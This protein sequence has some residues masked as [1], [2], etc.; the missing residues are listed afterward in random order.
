MN[1]SA[2][3]LLFLAGVGLP[4]LLAPCARAEAQGT[5]APVVQP[6]RR[7]ALDPKFS[8]A[9]VIAG[10][11]DGDGA[12]EIVSARNVNQNDV[13]FTCA[14]VA[15]H[16][17]GRVLWRW[18]NPAIGRKELHHD[19]A[20]QIYD[21]DG[22]GRN[23]VV[24]CTEDSLVE[25]DGA[26]GKE[27]RRLP[28][29]KDASDCLVFVNL[30]GK[31]HATDVLVKDRY[32]QIWAFN[33]D[34]KQLWTVRNPGGYKTAHQPVPVDLDGDD[35]DEIMAGFAMLNPDGSTR[36]TF[37]SQKVDQNRG[38]CDCFRLVRAG[39]KPEDFRFVMTLCGANGIALL[40]GGGKPLW[41]ITGH[42]FESVD[43]GRICANSQGLQFAVDIDH[44]PKGEGPVWIIDENGQVK[45]RIKA[46][47]VRFH[48]LVDW[49]GDGLDEIVMAQ[50]RA[51]YDGQ[52]RIVARLA[53]NP[54]DDTDGA[55]IVMTGDFTG[56]GV[57]DVMLTTKAMTH[58]FIYKNE[59]GRKPH[60]SA[61]LGTG[62]NFTL[63]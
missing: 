19:V 10:D 16:L 25:L 5:A 59:R 9:W 27:K 40:D 58:V 28:L 41:E 17:D 29:P 48:A 47:W 34:W 57:P 6:W 36:W 51:L 8:G 3:N 39:K 23:E 52:G 24:L 1:R 61:P 13:H 55:G 12:V 7:I 42:H 2:A 4:W 43:V 33:H 38:H 62:V 60:P 50:P 14:V 37:Q 21:W 32:N 30:S 35:R 15:Q 31:P 53:M 22:D 46:D 56:D 26:T 20:C 18:G 11:L 63:Y 49:T 54:R 45:T 44:A